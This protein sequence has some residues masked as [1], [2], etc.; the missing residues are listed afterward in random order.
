MTKAG[1]LDRLAQGVTP[2]Q[3]VLMVAV[4]AKAGVDKNK[5]QTATMRMIMLVQIPKKVI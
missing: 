2:A 3:D 1:L 4:S 5:K